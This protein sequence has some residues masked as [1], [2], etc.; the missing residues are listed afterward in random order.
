MTDRCYATIDLARIVN[1][2][3]Y[4]KKTTP[5]RNV[6][7]VVKADAY[8]HG[9]VAVSGAV[10]KEVSALCVATCD[11]GIELVE[12]HIKNDILVLEPLLSRDVRRAVEYNMVLTVQDQSNLDEISAAA[13]QMKTVA[14]VNVAVCCNMNRLGAEIGDEA[15]KL[16]EKVNDS[17]N[18]EIYG[19]FSHI[20]TTK[21]GKKIDTYAQKSKL[22]RWTQQLISRGINT[23]VLHLSA[24]DDVLNGGEIWGNAVRIGMAM[25]GYGDSNGRL[26]PAM[27]LYSKVISLRTVAAGTPVGYDEAW[28]AQKD[29]LLATLAIGY[30]DGYPLALS[31]KGIVKIRG[32]KA[33]IVGRVCMDMC[34]IDASEIDGICVGDVAEMWGDNVDLN[35]LA[36]ISDSSVYELLARVG[37]RID[38]IY[39][40]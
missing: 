27:S 25:Y 5:V 40:E 26:A 13:K 35:Y 21:D 16:I 19:I 34:M 12:N 3:R 10:E 8:G 33:P 36:S 23:G 18:V 32:K 29:T 4:V 15:T 38:K 9:A 20:N 22:R 24:T 7:G 37:K 17:D 30:A 28:I 2:L 14:R 6:M 1:N 31:N 11:E 39:V